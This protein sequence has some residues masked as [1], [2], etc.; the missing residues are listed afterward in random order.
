MQESDSMLKLNTIYSYRTMLSK[1]REKGVMHYLRFVVKKLLVAMVPKFRKLYVFELDVSK[2]CE[3]FSQRQGIDVEVIRN[4]DEMITFIKEREPWYYAY[5]KGLM[6]KGNLCFVGK[7]DN[8]IVSCVWTSFNEVYLSDVEY[9][10][11]VNARTVPLIDGYTLPEYRKMGVYSMVWRRC[12]EYFQKDPRYTRIY[13][14]ITSSNLG[15]LVV[16]RKLEL[17]HVIMQ[18][19]LLRIF[20]IRKHFMKRCV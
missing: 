15:S 13:G 4:L 6:E 3:Q 12:I 2:F 11:R 8:R 19:T 9:L 16:H 5:A 10:L 18:I 17:M 7:I 14:F 20:G 1:L